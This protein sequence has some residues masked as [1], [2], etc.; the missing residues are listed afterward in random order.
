LPN[1][2]FASSILLAFPRSSPFLASPGYLFFVLVF[3]HTLYG[4]ARISL[5]HARARARV[6]DT[7]MRAR[8][9]I[10]TSFNAVE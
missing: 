5:A 4:L 6:F 3:T 9:K 2:F 1:Y 10:C 8:G 7:G